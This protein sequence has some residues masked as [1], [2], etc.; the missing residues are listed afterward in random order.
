MP[1]ARTVIAHLIIELGATKIALPHWTPWLVINQGLS[2]PTTRKSFTLQVGWH[3]SGT[4]RMLVIHHW[5]VVN[6]AEFFHEEA[7]R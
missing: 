4:A 3:C 7:E 1:A 2:I 5:I 6:V